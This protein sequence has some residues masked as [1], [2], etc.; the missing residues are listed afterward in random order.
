[1]CDQLPVVPLSVQ[2]TFLWMLE[3]LCTQTVVLDHIGMTDLPLQIFS[4]A[5]Q[6][7]DLS[8]PS[9]LS[10]RWR[11]GSRKLSQGQTIIALHC[12]RRCR[13]SWIFFS[14]HSC[15]T[16]PVWNFWFG[17]QLLELSVE[18]STQLWELDIHVDETDVIQQP[19]RIRCLWPT[20]VW[21]DSPLKCDASERGRLAA[22]APGSLDI[23]SGKNK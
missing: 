6:G 10:H 18:V 5:P 23:S 20:M 16:S 19:W 7:H 8:P 12:S 11:P 1:M 15:L 22:A 3:S 14:N 21:V 13:F 17:S 4:M 9:L 2:T